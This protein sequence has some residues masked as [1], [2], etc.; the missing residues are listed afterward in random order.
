M[1]QI[2]PQFQEFDI[3]VVFSSICDLLNYL[4][5]FDVV[6]EE[7]VIGLGLGLGFGASMVE[8]FLWRHELRLQERKGRWGAARGRGE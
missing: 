5:Q 8:K 3:E 2:G 4:R 1:L 7:D 6:S